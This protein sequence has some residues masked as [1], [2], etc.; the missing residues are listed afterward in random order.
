MPKSNFVRPD[1]ERIFSDK[2]NCCLLIKRLQKKDLAEKVGVHRGTLSKH[3]AHP[4]EMN[5]GELKRIIKIAKVPKED[6][7]EYLFEE[8]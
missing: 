1:Y 3:F 8:R 5:V 6:I 4:Q 7:I 2:L